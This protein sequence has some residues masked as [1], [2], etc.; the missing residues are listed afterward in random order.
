LLNSP[1]GKVD[2]SSKGVKKKTVQGQMMKKESDTWKTFNGETYYFDQNGKKVRGFCNI[3]NERYYFDASGVMLKGL[4][5]IDHE[6]YYFGTDG[7]MK[8]GWVIQ[9]DGYQYFNEKGVMMRELSVIDGKTYYFDKNGYRYTGLLEENNTIKYFNKQGIMETGL[10]VIDGKTYYFDVSGNAFVGNKIFDGIQY[11][12]GKNGVLEKKIS[13]SK[14]KLACVVGKK[15]IGW[16]VINGEKCFFNNY[17]KLIKANAKKVIDVSY[18]QGNIDWKKVKKEAGVD[19][20]IIRIGYTALGNKSKNLDSYFAKN[21]KGVIQY[22]IPY[23]FYYYGYAK[24]KKEAEAE[25]NLVLTTLRKYKAKPV[26]PIYYDAEEGSISKKQYEI[27]ITTFNEMLKKAGYQVGVYG[28]YS[29]FTYSYLNSKKIK[30]YP[31]WIAQW[32]SVCTYLGKYQMWQYTNQGKIPGIRGR[33][34]V[35][36]L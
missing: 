17:G 6:T 16:Q 12:F 20:V 29:A 18:W 13:V 22:K 4:Q 23:G 35:S 9:K 8:K 10:Q 36:V 14:K 11:S 24:T 28:N 7:K 34:D 15:L 19:G 3:L 32:N 30:Q 26:F 2:T 25:A 1:V 33:V 5:V 27:V 21:L 31:I